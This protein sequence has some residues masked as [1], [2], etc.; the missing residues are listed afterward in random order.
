MFLSNVTA[1]GAYDSAMRGGY[2]GGGVSLRTPVRPINLAAFDPPRISA[3]CAG[4][5]MYGGSFSFINANQIV[6][7]FRQIMN[8]ATGL[9]FKAALN[10]ICPSCSNMMTEFQKTV[11]DLN[12]LASNTCAIANGVISTFAPNALDAAG[13]QAAANIGSAIGTF[14]DHFT[15]I[16]PASTAQSKQDNQATEAFNASAGNFVWKALARSQAEKS[17]A[18]TGGLAPIGNQNEQRLFLMS[19]VGTQS[20]TGMIP[21]SEPTNFVPYGS[22]FKLHDLIDADSLLLYDCAAGGPVVAGDENVYGTNSC[23]IL[24]TKAFD[25][26]GTLKYVKN[27]LYGNGIPSATKA[28]IDIAIAGGAG[29]PTAG[30]ILYKFKYCVGGGC[31]LTPQQQAFLYLAGPLVKYIKE[32]QLQPA[33]I[34]TLIPYIE[35]KIA[36]EIVI[37]MG[38]ITVRALQNAWDGVQDVNLPI[39]IS[40]SIRDLGIQLVALNAESQAERQNIQRADEISEQIRKSLHISGR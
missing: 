35:R 34:E 39:Q 18:D 3:G 5:D 25:F 14:T 30:S 31:S 16:S 11:Q 32:A 22:R 2:V 4:I 27:M 20:F 29:N 13:K 6:V 36:L 28:A 1:P 9:L 10:N 21:G 15:G 17:L 40:E 33:Q 7:L 12:A 37:K 8:N 19:L 24:T 38:E 23:I 26:S